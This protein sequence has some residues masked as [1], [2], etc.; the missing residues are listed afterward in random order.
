MRRTKKKKNINNNVLEHYLNE[1]KSR[2]VKSKRKEYKFF[3]NKVKIGMLSL[4]TLHGLLLIIAE[5]TE[6]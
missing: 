3:F 5:M 2:I 6:L 4:V 1:Q